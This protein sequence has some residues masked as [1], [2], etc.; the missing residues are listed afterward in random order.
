MKKLLNKSNYLIVLITVLVGMIIH[1]SIY[2]KNLLSADILLY[3]SFYNS[4]L[5]EIS[6]GR[7]GLFIIGILKSYL[8]I[9]IIEVFSSLIILGIINVLLIDLLKI[10]NKYLSIVFITCTPIISVSLLFYYC[11][12]SYMIGMLAIVLSVYLLYKL[13]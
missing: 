11:S 1:F 6:L 10:K 5:W 7:F 13:K 8:S 9:P 2:T 12:F 4:Y 3:N